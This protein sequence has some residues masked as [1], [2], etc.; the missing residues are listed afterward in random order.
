MSYV[1]FKLEKYL[2]RKIEFVE[3]TGK[4]PNLCSGILTIKVDNVTY[5]LD[6]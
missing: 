2:M 3:Y 1:S 5:S 6:G 4:Y